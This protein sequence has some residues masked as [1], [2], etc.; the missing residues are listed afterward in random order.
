MHRVRNL[1]GQDVRLV[2][3]AQKSATT[4]N[5]WPHTP[6]PRVFVEGLP[7]PEEGVIFIVKPEVLA[8]CDRADLFTPTQPCVGGYLA[9][10]QTSP[11]ASHD[12]TV[13]G[14]AMVEILR[15]EE[16]RPG[17]NLAY[18]AAI[19]AARTTLDNVCRCFW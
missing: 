9:L 12:I 16:E 13:V 7:A 15:R 18:R 14:R 5:P 8:A 19:V 11:L 1:T 10:Q 17:I 2:N 6:P 3:P 4:H